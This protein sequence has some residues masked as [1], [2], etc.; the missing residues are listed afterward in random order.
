MHYIAT[1]LASDD[2]QKTAYVVAVAKFDC[3]R[4]E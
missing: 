1:L 3:A 2:A 4:T